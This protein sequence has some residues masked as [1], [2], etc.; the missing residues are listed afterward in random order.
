MAQ[1]NGEILAVDIFYPFRESHPE[2][3]WG[4]FPSLISAGS[5]S[6]YVNCS[7]IGEFS[8]ENALTAFLDDLFSTDGIPCRILMDNGGPGL[9]S[10]DWAE[11]MGRFWAENSH[12]PS[13]HSIAKRD[14]W[15][16][17]TATKD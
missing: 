1:Y 15:T 10:K 16:R 4:G 13:H 5:L 3:K 2:V 11:D 12:G 7:A 17:C 8:G 6:R 9:R 14:R